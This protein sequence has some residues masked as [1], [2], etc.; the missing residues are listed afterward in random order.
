MSIASLF[1]KKFL[2]HRYDGEPHFRYFTAEDF[3]GLR[4]DPVEFDSDG[5]LLRGFFYSYDGCREDTL[6]IFCHGIGGGHRSYLAEIE[7]LCKAGYRVLAYDNTGCFASEGKD[8]RSMSRSLADLDNAV[9]F[10]KREG[11]FSRYEHVYTI[12]HSW[13][14]FA[15]GAIPQYQKDIRKTVVISGFLSVEGILSSG[16]LSMKIPFKKALL[17]GFLSYEAKSDPAHLDASIPLAM[18]QGNCRYFI[19]HSE[20]DG[21]VPYKEN[22]AVL[23]ERF[24]DAEYLIVNGK[25]HNPNYAKDAVDYMNETFGSYSRLVKEKKLRTEE[26]K[27][28]FMENADWRR[29][30]AQD[31]AFWDKVLHFLDD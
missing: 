11:I 18:E 26:E 4:A 13:G 12:G 1:Y 25:K 22:A 5:N 9:N 14:G 2:V 10:L 17:K 23:K 15:A 19:A 31:P 20:D 3:P 16:I 30:T 6:L 24:T 21:V 27:E 8:I 29:M 28:R 7:T